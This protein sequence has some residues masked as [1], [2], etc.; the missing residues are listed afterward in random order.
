MA[1]C[2]DNLTDIIRNLLNG[3]IFAALNRTYIISSYYYAKGYRRFAL[4][5]RIFPSGIIR[6]DISFPHNAS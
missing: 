1:D 2:T 4:F 3:Y 5:E 6:I